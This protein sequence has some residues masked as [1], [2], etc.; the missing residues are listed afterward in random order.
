MALNGPPDGLRLEGFSEG[1]SG[2]LGQSLMR[3]N[4]GG[5]SVP[6]PVIAVPCYRESSQGFGRMLLEFAD[7]DCENVEVI[8]TPG[9]G[10]IIRWPRSIHRR[11]RPTR[12]ASHAPT[13]I[14][15][16]VTV[17]AFRNAVFQSGTFAIF[18]H[19]L[20][21]FRSQPTGARM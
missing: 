19:W 15:G 7:T 2:Y 18:S 10:R 9:Q 5:E 12:T 20:L 3:Y 1:A 17:T 13:V 6:L 8:M 21:A 14:V 16:I 4:Y 11:R